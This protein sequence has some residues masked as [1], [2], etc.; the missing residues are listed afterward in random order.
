MIPEEVAEIAK[1]LAREIVQGSPNYEDW[2]GLAW[3]IY[4]SLDLCNCP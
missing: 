3:K 1:I 4:N 2:I